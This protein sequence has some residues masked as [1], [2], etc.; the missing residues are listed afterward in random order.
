[1]ASDLIVLLEPGVWLTPTRDDPC[2]RTLVRSSAR[3][4][5]TDRAARMALTKARKYREF[6][7]AVVEVF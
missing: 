1:M 3:K 5:P 7:N 4:F 6:P 2:G